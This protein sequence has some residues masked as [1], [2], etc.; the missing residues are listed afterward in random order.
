MFVAQSFSKN[1][2]LYSERIGC[3]TMVC[4]SI[5]AMERCRTQLAYIT[6]ALVSNPPAFGAKIATLIINTPELY[7]EW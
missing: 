7:Y 1:L 3:L 4:S 5:S 6:R 2:G